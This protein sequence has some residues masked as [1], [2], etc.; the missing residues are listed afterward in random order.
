LSG[1]ESK[2]SI[3]GLFASANEIEVRICS[4]LSA[5][6]FFFGDALIFEAAE[7]V[8]DMKFFVPFAGERILTDFQVWSLPFSLSS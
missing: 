7:I 6:I 4:F 5:K 1:F 2:S 8:G 3:K